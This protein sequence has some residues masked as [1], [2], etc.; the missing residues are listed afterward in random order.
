MRNHPNVK[1]QTRQLVWEEARRLNYQPNQLASSLR[2]GKAHAIGV[3]TPR[4]NRNFFAEVISGIEQVT[5][6]AGYQLLICQS[7]E[8]FDREEKNLQGLLANR[9][10]GVL[11]SISR[12][13][14]THAHLDTLRDAQ[15]P[16]VQFD[17]IIPGFQSPRVINADSE[18]SREIIDH[19]YAQGYRR[20]AFLGG[21][22][23]INIYQNR[24]QGYREGMQAYG[25]EVRP[26]WQSFDT[27]TEETSMQRV[28]AWFAEGGEV[29]DAIFTAGDYSALGAVL[30]LQKL[31]IPIPE[32]VG[33]VG[34]ANE[35]FTPHMTPPL[36][37]VDQRSE[38][39]GRLAAA[40]LL[41]VIHG[42]DRNDTCIDL[43][44]RLIIRG[45]STRNQLL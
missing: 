29:P 7:I 10:D 28:K 6:G 34:Y 12:E 26:G 35:P 2:R 27:L 18:T 11:I 38:E 43:K 21:P 19:L 4:I 16:V 42:S 22:L 24:Y 1:E 41:E 45:S 37:T 36:S 20:I 15:I 40:L 32:A 9:V 23:E 8:R 30:A 39:M 13:T 17:R 3:V 14:R 44:P 31:G 25:L 5:Y 33:V